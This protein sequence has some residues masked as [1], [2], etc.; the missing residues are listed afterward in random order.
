MTTRK[1]RA[2]LPPNLGALERKIRSLVDE[3]AQLKAIQKESTPA[4]EDLDPES[5][6]S[7]LTSSVAASLGAGSSLSGVT[8]HDHD[9]STPFTG[10]SGSESMNATVEMPRAFFPDNRLGII[11]SGG[12]SEELAL[13]A[14]DHF[15]KHILVEF[16]ILVIPPEIT[17]AEMRTV[18]PVLFLA[19]LNAASGLFARWMQDQLNRELTDTFARLIL[20]EGTKSLELV[21]ALQVGTLW[22]HVQPHHRDS[23]YYQLASSRFKHQ[24]WMFCNQTFRD[25]RC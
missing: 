17:A 19:I 3:V 25:F 1:P 7:R 5:L 20:V 6:L 24:Y 15:T 4:D 16:P 23:R 10:S 14:F 2:R 9:F 22:L 21:Q 12:L 18:K 11:T 13:E 8:D